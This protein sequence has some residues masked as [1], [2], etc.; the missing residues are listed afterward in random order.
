M[1]ECLEELQSAYSDPEVF[2][3]NSNRVV[4]G[5][6][7]ILFAPENMYP[8]TDVKNWQPCVCQTMDPEN[9]L[10]EDMDAAFML[11]TDGSDSM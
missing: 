7:L 8:W 3:A 9:D 1:P 6:R 10:E 11:T 4:R 5:H 2:P